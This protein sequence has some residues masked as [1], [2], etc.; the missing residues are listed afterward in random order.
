MKAVLEFIFYLLLLC[1][2]VLLVFGLKAYS[3]DTPFMLFPAM[4]CVGGALALMVRRWGR[5]VLFVAIPAAILLAAL[6]GRKLR[7]PVASTPLRPGIYVLNPRHCARAG[8]AAPVSA[9]AGWQHQDDRG[10]GC[11]PSFQYVH[12][13]SWSFSAALKWSLWRV[14]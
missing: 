5:I 4:L 7:L 13:L 12:H 8:T 3:L 1:G 2:G 10:G 11:A 9:A 6:A 14:A